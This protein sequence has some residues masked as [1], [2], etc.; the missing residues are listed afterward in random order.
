MPRCA[1]RPTPGPR[2]SR[3]TF[4]MTKR[5][6]AGAWAARRAGG[7]MAA[8]RRSPA[9]SPGSAELSSYAKAPRPRC[10]P[11][12][13]RRPAQRQ[14]TQPRAIGRGRRVSNATS[15][16]SAKRR[17]AELR[18][19]PGR[20]SVRT[21][22]D[23]ALSRVHAVLEGVPC[24]ARAAH[25]PAS[26]QDRALRGRRRRDARELQ[27]ASDHARLGGRFARHLDAGRTRRA[28]AAASFHRR[29]SCRL[30]RRPRRARQRRPPRGF[31]LICI[32]ASSA[33]T[34][35]GTRSTMP[36]PARAASWT[37]AP[38]PSC[39]SSA[40]A[41]SRII[42]CTASR[43]SPTRR[44]GRNSHASLGV[45]TRARLTPGGA[46]RRA[47]PSSMRRCASCGGPA[48]CRTARA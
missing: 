23:Q 9:T 18:L 27:T 22:R 34:R 43:R 1:R 29:R 2:F 15:A 40:G 41:N 14:S 28:R 39:A 16:R 37:A 26:A 31:R 4:S 12:C 36:R 32:S 19:F 44:S 10:S 17:D 13:F 30:C 21:R 45:T 33:P 7:S 6:D 35:S 42:C 8:S 20:L 3:F 38:K 48:S 25:A 11:R 5:P 46:A 47:T 24:R